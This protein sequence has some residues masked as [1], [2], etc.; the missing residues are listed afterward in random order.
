MAWLDSSGKIEPLLAKP[1]NYDSPRLSPDGQ[2]LA[3]QV[4]AGKSHAAYVYDLQR[5]IMSRLTATHG[6][7]AIW[8]PDGKHLAFTL[9]SVI[10]WIRAD[11]LA[12]RT[13]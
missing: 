13:G 5:D 9:N 1:G 2:R 4:T 10:W 3:L 7:S 6:D 8:A 11:G 12:S